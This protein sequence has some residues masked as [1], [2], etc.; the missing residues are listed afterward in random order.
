MRFA[1][2]TPSFHLDYELCRILVESVHRHVPEDVPHFIIVSGD[3]L[4]MFRGLADSRT[5]VR[6]QEDVVDVPFWRVPFARTWRVSLQTPP[7]RGWVW[8]QLVKMSIANSI[9]ADAYLIVDSDCFFVRPF[10]PRTLVVDGKVPLYR[11]EKDWYKTDAPSQK[12]ANVS[13]RLLRLPELREPY[14]VG[15]V[16]PWGIWRRDV[17]LKLQ[18]HLSNGGSS[19]GWLRKVGTQMTISEYMLYGMFVERVLGLE[20]SGHYSFGRHIAYEYW[21]DTPLDRAGLDKFRSGIAEH[22]MVMI[23]A[24][25]RTPESDIRAAFGY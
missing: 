19:S 20:S 9:D 4:G 11:E 3:D 17:L 12:W 22:E 10:D 2:V 1:L 6:V 8:Q 14:P 13:Q 18:K 25:S 23:N 24:K 7:V 15:Y 16:N 5:H 21:S